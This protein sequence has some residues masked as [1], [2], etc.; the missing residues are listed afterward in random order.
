MFIGPRIEYINGIPI[1]TEL[2]KHDAK[3]N[4]E[5]SSGLKF[6]KYLLVKKPVKKIIIP[7]P[8]KDNIN[9]NEFIGGKVT[10]QK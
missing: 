2:P 1:A 9:P 4:N 10:C 8:K 7:D 6:N 3:P 5:L